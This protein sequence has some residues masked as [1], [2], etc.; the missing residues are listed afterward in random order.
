MDNFVLVA[1][2]SCTNPGFVAMFGIFV[3]TYKHQN[4]IRLIRHPIQMR[5]R[6]QEM[7]GKPLVG[8]PLASQS[9][10]FLQGLPHS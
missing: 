9:I 5:T 3:K 7:S 6:L 1:K 10:S 4:L 2:W 8:F